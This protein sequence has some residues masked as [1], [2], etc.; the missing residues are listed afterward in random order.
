MNREHLL[1]DT[2]QLPVIEDLAGLVLAAQALIDVRAP[3][4]FQEGA[5]PQATNLP[6][7]ND[8]ERAMIGKR[9]KDAGQ[10]QAIRLGLE[11]VSGEQKAQRIEAWQQFALA[12]PQGALYCFRGGLR[13][14]ITQQWLYSATG[15]AYPRIAGGYKALR[16]YLLDELAGLP[17]RYQAYVLSGRTGCGKTRF[18]NTLKQ[19]ID[20]EGLANHRGSAFG[21]Q[22]KPQPSQIDFENALTIKL[23]QQLAKG[24]QQLVFEDESRSIGSIHLPDSLFFSLRTAPIVLLETSQAERLELTYQDYILDRLQAF[25]QHFGDPD[26]ALSA[27]RQSLLTSLAKLQKR[28]GGVRYAKALAY[29]QL[30][31]AQQAKTGETQLHQAWIEF[32]L[33]DYYDPMYDYQI[34]Q[35]RERIVFVG[36]IQAVLAFFASHSIH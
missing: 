33:T 27:F 6:L 29:L 30:A 21:A 9:Y 35:K 20:L 7:M 24:Y 4:E 18:L 12:H 28:L 11:L 34:S 14:R 25:Q 16:R 26:Q 19:V 23:L 15:I 13:S 17:R 8:A 10:D 22:V 1:P 2:E 32:L 31:L 36:D 3:I 5:F